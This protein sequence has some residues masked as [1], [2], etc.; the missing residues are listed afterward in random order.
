MPE[1]T[2]VESKDTWLPGSTQWLIYH[3]GLDECNG[4]TNIGRP[5]KLFA[6]GSCLISP[7]TGGLP[8][9]AGS[10]VIPEA[11]QNGFPEDGVAICIENIGD[12][13]NSNSGLQL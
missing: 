5:R 2:E 8:E 10:Q 13:T 11:F 4:K 6:K 7:I 1:R 9:A 12:M 3:K